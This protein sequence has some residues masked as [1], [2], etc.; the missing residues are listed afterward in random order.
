MGARVLTAI[1]T[2]IS[3]PVKVMP[4]IIQHSKGSN[5]S[6]QRL[7]LPSVTFPWINEGDIARRHL[8]G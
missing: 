3:K 2:H 4:I 8:L 1:L 6:G 7:P 5:A